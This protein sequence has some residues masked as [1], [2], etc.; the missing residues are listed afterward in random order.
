[1]ADETTL[2][3]ATLVALTEYL[4]GFITENKGQRFDEVLAQRTRHIVVALEDIYQPHNASAT[5]RSCDCFGI[6]ELHVIENRNRYTINPSITLGSSKWV[7]LH[8]WN[9]PEHDN[10]TSC[11]SGLKQR[12]YRLVATTPHTDNLLP[13]LDIQEPVAL[14]FGTEETGLTD[15]ALELADERVRIPMYGFTES[16]NISVSVALTLH[17]VITRMHRSELDWGLSERDRQEIRYRWVKKV[18]KKKK[19]ELLERTFFTKRTDSGS[20]T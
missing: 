6:Q 20:T 9:T 2:D 16:F 19:S 13:D 7:E 4:S 12:G 18:L 10:T 15:T 1:M 11:L 14:L 5:V 8:R 3:T 17:D